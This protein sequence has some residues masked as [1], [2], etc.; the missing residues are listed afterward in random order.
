MKPTPRNIDVNGKTRPTTSA[1][2]ASPKA[3][4]DLKEAEG[5]IKGDSKKNECDRVGRVV[6]KEREEENPKN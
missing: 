5:I 1:G 4:D 2:I 3:K 6:Y